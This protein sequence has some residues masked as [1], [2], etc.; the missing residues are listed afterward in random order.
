MIKQKTMYFSFVAI[1][2]AV[3]TFIFRV[4]VETAFIAGSILVGLACFAI[5]P[6]SFWYFELSRNYEGRSPKVVFDW[7][8]QSWS[9]HGDYLLLLPAIIVAMH[10]WHNRLT[11]IPSW[12]QQWWW[13]YVTAAAG[14]A[15]GAFFRWGD[16]GRYPPESLKGP[17]K[18]FHDWVLIPIFF[19]MLVARGVPLLWHMDR[20]TLTV[21][22]L[23]GCWVFLAAIDGLRS[24]TGWNFVGSPDWCLRLYTKYRLDPVYQHV[25]WDKVA[26]RPL[27]R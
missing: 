18:T 20:Y 1:A 3:Y 5:S 17:A 13:F 9:F 14:V 7:R 24:Y 8:R 26:F 23:V 22:G 16:N 4:S 27:T 2:L 21:L 6:L 10:V 25:M 15:F 19:G 11:T 12:F